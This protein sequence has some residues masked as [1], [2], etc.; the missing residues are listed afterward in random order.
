MKIFRDTREQQKLEFEIGGETSE[1]IDIKLPF[2]DYA[3]GW[4]NKKGEFVDFFP[5]FFE[6]KSLGDLFGTLGKGMERFKKE[7]ERAK[8]AGA[9]LIIIID[10]CMDEVEIGYKHSSIRGESI[11]RTLWTL[12]VKYDVPFILCNDTKDMVKTIVNCFSAI[13]RNFKP[14]KKVTFE[15]GEQVEKL[16][17]MAQTEGDDSEQPENDS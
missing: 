15:D 10:G 1:V 5:V 6:R 14:E 2:G 16:K 7:I 11:L 17:R 8:Q 4:E 3:G 9:H 12:W 13:G